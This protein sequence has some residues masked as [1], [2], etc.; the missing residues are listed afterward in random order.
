MGEEIMNKVVLIGRMTKDAQLGYT[1]NTQKAVAKFTLAVDR[2]N[3]GAD[4]INCTAFG[5]Q[6]EIIEKFVKKGN[7]LAVAGRIQT[8]SYEKDGQKIY[9]TDVIV[10]NAE[11]IE[12]KKENNEAHK[13]ETKEP[14][15]QFDA[16]DFDIPF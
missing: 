2:I 5:K 12:P 3:E 8:G 16:I 10:D 7:R 13:E 4:F 6:A 1:S 9:T 11:F 15:P 14:E